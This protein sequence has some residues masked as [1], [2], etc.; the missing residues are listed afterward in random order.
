MH[1]AQTTNA[2]ATQNIEL[3]FCLYAHRF[4]EPKQC[5]SSHSRPMGFFMTL[6]AIWRLLQCLRRYH[7]TR[8]VFPHLV[9]GGKYV[10]TILSYVTLSLY[11]VEGT[12]TNL[13]LYITTS[14]IN[15][16]YTCEWLT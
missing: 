7:D 15:A 12:H 8:N 16:I 4:N 10:M 2:A 3:F 14:L 13:A 5:N 1:E 9:N 6:P 11:R